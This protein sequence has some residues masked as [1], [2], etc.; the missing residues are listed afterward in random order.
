[1]STQ[2]EH[3]ELHNYFKGSPPY[4]SVHLTLLLLKCAPYIKMLE[5]D[6]YIN[7][8]TYTSF[9]LKQ[10]LKHEEPDKLFLKT[11]LI[12]FLFFSSTKTD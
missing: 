10:C 2:V 3:F 6:G 1:M 11:Y 4:Y 12:G 8:T 9:H 7:K 5:K